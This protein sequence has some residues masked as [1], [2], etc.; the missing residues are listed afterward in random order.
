MKCAMKSLRS[1]RKRLTR[2]RHSDFSGGFC[3]GTAIII[4]IAMATNSLCMPRVIQ[5]AMPDNTAAPR[6]TI[7]PSPESVP[8]APP[9]ALLKPDGDLPVILTR[10]TD[11]RL[12]N[13]PA[14]HI[15]KV[16]PAQISNNPSKEEIIYAKVFPFPMIPIGTPPAE[17]SAAVA[18]AIIEFRDRPNKDNMA[19]LRTFINTRLSGTWT[20]SLL[21][22]L[23][24]AYLERGYFSRALDAWEQAW[25]YLNKG[26]FA[27]GSLEQTLADEVFSHLITVNLRLGQ[28]ERVRELIKEEDGDPKLGGKATQSLNK[29]KELLHYFDVKAEENA[30]CGIRALNA[31][32]RHQAG[33]KELVPD[34]DDPQQIAD[35]IAN[36]ISLAD[37]AERAP[38]GGINYQMAFRSGD[39]AIPTPS[40]IHWKFGH[41]SALT[42]KKDDLYRLEDPYLG[43]NNWISAQ[44]LTA[45]GSGYYLIPK[46]KMLP[47][48]W[49][50]VSKAEGQ[51]VLGRHC[52][53]GRTEDGNSP[54]T[55]CPTPATGMA[56]YSFELLQAGLVLRDT[57]IGYRPPRGL[58]VYFT[59]KYRQRVSFLP[60]F[61]TYSNSGKQWACSWISYIQPT[62]ITSGNP[63]QIRFITGDALSFTYNFDSASNTYKSADSIYY[64]FA[65]RRNADG[66]YEVSNSDGSRQVFAQPDS[67]SPARMFLTTAYD[68][69]GNQVTLIYDEHIRLWKI[70][71]ALSQVTELFY[72]PDDGSVVDYQIRRIRDP[73]GREAS[74]EYDGTRLRSSTDVGGLTSTFDYG[75][76]DFINRL[77]TPYGATTFVSS[78]AGFANSVEA[79]D[80]L[81]GVEQ[82]K[83]NDQ[84][85]IPMQSNSP[86]STSIT[87]DGISVPFLVS[88]YNLAWRNSYYWNKKA[89]ADAPGDYN[90][91]VVYH[92]LANNSGVTVGIPESYKLPLEERVWFNYP[93]QTQ[94]TVPGT[95]TK[96]SKIARVV[97]TENGPTTQL[98]QISYNP[99]GQISQ[100][101]DPIGRKLTYDYD[102]NNLIDLLHIRQTRGTANEA[103]FS[104]AYNT[105]HRPLTV[106]DAANQT[107]TMTYNGFGQIKT[108]TNPKGEVTTF[109]YDRDDDH[110]GSTDG[111]LQS[112]TGNDPAAKISFTRDGFNRVQSK[113]VPD[114]LSSPG[115]TLT[116]DYDDFDRVTK[117]TYPDGSYEQ[118]SYK[119][120]DLEWARDRLGR[121]TKYFVDANR[122][123]LAVEN[124]LSQVTH[125]GWCGCGAIASISDALNHTTSWDYDVQ[126]RIRSKT[127]ADNSSTTV[128]YQ[129]LS[130][131]TGSITDAKQQVTGY[132]YQLDD[133]VKKVSYTDAG[134][135]PLASTPTVTFQYDPNYN[136]L[137]SMS[138]PVTG[139]TA[140]AYK[141]AGVL[142][143]G[144]VDTVDGPL[145]NDTIS[146]GYDQLGRQ[147]SRAING[148]SASVD[149]D[150]LG[151]PESITNPLGAFAYHY[152]GATS[153]LE[154]TDIPNGQHTAF[155]YFD[156]SGDRRLQQIKH[157]APPSVG[158][159]IG[160][161]DYTYDTGGQIKSW[162][163]ADSGSPDAKRYEVNY[164]GI[165]QITEALVKNAS[166]GALLKQFAYHYDAAGNRTS[167]QIDQ[168]IMKAVPNGVNQITSKEAGGPLRFAGTVSKP[169]TVTVAG[170]PANVDANNNFVGYADV[171]P[172]DNTLAIVAKDAEGR[173]TT[174]N[175]R[176]SAPAGETR[177]YGY[178]GNGNLQAISSSTFNAQYEWDALNRLS[179]VVNG[180]HRSEFT[181]NGLSQRVKIVEKD[182]GAV[183][184]TKQ[185]VWVLGETQP[186]EE[187]DGSNNVTKR[188]YLQGVQIG[189]T[190]YYYTRDHLGSVRELTDSSGAVQVRYDYDPY[191]RRTKVTGSID[192]D[193][194]F[195]G[196]YFHGP[197]GLNFSPTR[198]YDSDLGRWVNRDPIS[199]LGGINLY[200]YVS[201]NP[202]TFIDPI[203][204]YASLAGF[205]VDAG[206]ATG[207]GIAIATA[208]PAVALAALAVGAAILLTPTSI[209]P[210]PSVDSPQPQP[211]MV[212]PG[213][214]PC[215]PSAKPGAPDPG[216]EDY[217]RRKAVNDAWAAEQD[218]VAQTGQGTRPWTEAEKAELLATGRVSGYQGHHISSVSANPQMAGDPN[219]I[220]FVRPGEHLDLHNGDWH[221]PTWGPVI[222]R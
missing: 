192:A 50:S 5:A 130:G 97:E 207:V 219:N 143:A 40:V 168:A 68:P 149:Y 109:D 218:M 173:T 137:S 117:V 13:I 98:T 20:P 67:A 180:T 160:Q 49:R 179:A 101:I 82:V 200:G 80:S 174:N 11:T 59:L 134:G 213:K 19:D 91:A 147:I 214:P 136:R 191:G 118:Y 122:Q 148:V 155:T 177:S 115:Y 204:L 124:P 79:H 209:G 43:F 53:H 73:F 96:P 102:P 163:M 27:R 38:E 217:L 86:P 58:S 44:A 71:D 26:V 141:P 181:Y 8:P 45:E 63:P 146:F 161:H 119:F 12:E 112:I 93:G 69:A 103:L 42:E 28:K 157:L 215:P 221:N 184:S 197:S 211:N 72:Q 199:E 17:E 145:A 31:N 182:N 120:L 190:N 152:I 39:A 153:L 164:D 23:G 140:Y 62:S 95:F 75:D 188:F 4:T 100:I 88:N 210:E 133:N 186:S 9:V 104:A 108:L 202:I 74:F 150:A 92:W 216:E 162:M 128:S 46:T 56:R 129:P 121:W 212:P 87:V 106:T 78:S 167:E 76:G 14:E 89:M 34:V 29:A 81:G 1:S 37:L 111:Y 25:K 10:H 170:K 189:S 178:D 123:V 15:V 90:K 105:Q 77:T 21:N 185:F 206:I 156:D 171:V 169:A 151:R 70:Y 48:G 172:G 51:K 220:Q 65:I 52:T 176:F 54:D 198:A 205:L 127:Y 195:T 183:T 175:Y 193:F 165:D 32:G 61:A 196:F 158:G 99:Q 126:G 6:V 60:D 2:R 159:I 222:P 24:V 16:G 142:G 166:T 116:Y 33:Y 36:G 144:R 187:R 154:S 110:D 64:G 139:V 135:T 203:G 30:S 57:P 18:R 114:G 7:T 47:A 107:T 138:D 201:N 55:D 132:T 208:S 84:G 35:Y 125:Y 131:R 66:S 94:P 22:Q 85:T 3:C 41:Y 113:S 83:A 194:G